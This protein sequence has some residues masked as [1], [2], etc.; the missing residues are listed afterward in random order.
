MVRLMKKSSG[1]KRVGSMLMFLNLW[2]LSKE[3]EVVMIKRLLMIDILVIKV[4]EKKE[5]D[6][7]L[8]IK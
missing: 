1:I 6:K 5:V 8:V 3:K 7:N 2:I 4:G